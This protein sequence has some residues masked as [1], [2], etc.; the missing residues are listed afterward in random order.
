MTNETLYTSTVGLSLLKWVAGFAAESALFSLIAAIYLTFKM[1]RV[2]QAIIAA[3]LI[4]PMLPG[5]LAGTIPA[6]LLK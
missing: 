1:S 6:W 2:S 3:F 5:Y 4:I